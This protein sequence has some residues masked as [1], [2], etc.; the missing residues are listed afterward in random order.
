MEHSIRFLPTLKH[1]ELW[2]GK[3]GSDDW[4]GVVLT[5]R[6]PALQGKRMGAGREG[7]T[8]LDSGSGR[9]GFQG[10]LR[11][12]TGGLG[13][14]QEAPPTPLGR[15]PRKKVIPAFLQEEWKSMGDGDK[16]EVR[17]SL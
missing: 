1:P 4:G 17:E 10:W 12:A 13:N 16:G 14:S 5:G 9:R 11:V 7:G 2:M 3:P 15:N 6:A 8:W